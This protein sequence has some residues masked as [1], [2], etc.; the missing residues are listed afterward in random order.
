MLQ[1]VS[2]DI[3]AT[4]Q[5]LFDKDKD[6]KYDE[7]KDVRLESKPI[8]LN[9][10]GWKEFHINI[11]ENE[12]KIISKN[13]NDDFSVIEDES[14]G[15]QVAYQSGKSFKPSMLETGI[16]LISERPN[17][18]VKQETAGT[19]DVNNGESFYLLKNYPNPFN[20]ETT[21][22]YTLKSAANVKITVYDR[23][24][25]EVTVLVDGSQSEGEHQVVFSAS[26]LPSGVY[27]YRLKTAEKTEVKKMVLAK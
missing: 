4:V 11:N 27:F 19:N 2:N 16:A 9:F 17:K 3:S 6:G 1:G 15:I 22:S 14:M 18:E 20:P 10:S 5:I 13:K 24:G 21:I 12:L 23:L 8:S 25:R 7:D 26:N